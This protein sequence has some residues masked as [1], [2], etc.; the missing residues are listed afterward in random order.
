MN[1]LKNFFKDYIVK[2]TKP[3]LITLPINLLVGLLYCFF[4]KQL[5]IVSY[6]NAL[7]IIGG[8]Y[9]VIGGMGFMG[10][11]SSELDY[12]K[13]FSR[14]GNQRNADN[15]SRAGFSIATFTI[16]ICTMLISFAVLAFQ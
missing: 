9:F 6:S 4:T 3:L 1:V 11:M 15:S 7:A 12:A 10:G 13:N 2:L 8:A 16:G 14:S 5:S